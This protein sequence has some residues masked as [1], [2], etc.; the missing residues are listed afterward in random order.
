MQGEPEQKTVTVGGAK[1]RYAEAGEGAPVIMLHGGGPGAW[2]LSNYRKNVPAF[3]RKFR[4]IVPDFPGFGGSE[5]L[6]VTAGLFVMLAD[7]ILG[8]MDALSIPKAS[9]VGNSLG[10]GTALRMTLKAPERIE[11]LVLMGP[12]GSIPVYTPMPTEGLLRMMTYYTGEGPTLEKLR[13][14]IDLLVFDPSTITED[15]LKER[16]QSSATPEAIANPPLKAFGAHPSDQ[17]WRD[18]IAGIRQRSLIIW[19]R[20]D[21]VVPLDCA[22]LLLKAMPNAE[23]HIFPNCGHWAQWEKADQFNALVTDFLDQP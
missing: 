16:F 2:G 17:I 20:E 23:L 14:V 8:L 21:R 6:P 18:N 3:A 22:F 9:I 15:L 4:V 5:R 19:G 7:M 1:I 12:A 11:R 13:K 10:G